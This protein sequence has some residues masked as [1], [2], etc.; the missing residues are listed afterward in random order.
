ML[1]HLI[2]L[3]VHQSKYVFLGQKFM[4]NKVEEGVFWK[5]HPPVE[6]VP[7][8]KEISNRMDLAVFVFVPTRRWQRLF[9][10]GDERMPSQMDL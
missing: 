2:C 9:S 1:F 6:T 3:Q 7:P 5:K 4:L 10:R 8:Q